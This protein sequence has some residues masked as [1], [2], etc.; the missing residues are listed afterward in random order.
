MLA[1]E[2][3]LPCEVDH[4]QGG[5]DAE[6]FAHKISRRYAILSIPT[7]RCAMKYTD[8][9]ANQSSFRAEQ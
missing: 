5:E 9:L 8:Q 7:G 1:D 3:L 6:F 2:L 4:G